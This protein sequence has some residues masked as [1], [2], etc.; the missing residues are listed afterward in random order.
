MPTIALTDLMAPV[1]D[2]FR[3]TL[4]SAVSAKV[5]ASEATSPLSFATK[6]DINSL[7]FHADDDY[8]K[9]ISGGQWKQGRT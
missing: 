7:V 1:G 4:R 9:R 5:I 3:L 8:R 2:G 6:G